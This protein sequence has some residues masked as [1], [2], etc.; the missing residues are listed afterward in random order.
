MQAVED[1]DGRS[2]PDLIALERLD[3]DLFR[4]RLNQKNMNDSLFGG[5]VLAQ[6]LT[7]ATLTVDETAPPRGVHSLHGYF[8]RSRRSALSVTSTV[9]PVSAS[10]ASHSPVI[11]SRVVIRKI[12]FNPSAMVMF[13]RTL[14]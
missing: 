3:R 2:V 6:S 7:A 11:P 5:Q 1:W 4:N 12:P 10:T 9:A 8:L 13:C 14:A